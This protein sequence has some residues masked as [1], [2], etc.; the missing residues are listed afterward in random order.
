MSERRSRSGGEDCSG[1][2]LDLLDLENANGIGVE[3]SGRFLPALVDPGLA[4]PSQES[5]P[6]CMGT[7]EFFLRRRSGW[8]Q[9][10]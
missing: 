6:V 1:I 9:S 8:I 10:Y 5:V 3:R 4:S 7:P 2:H